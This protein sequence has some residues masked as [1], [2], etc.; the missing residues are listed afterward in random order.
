MLLK[1]AVEIIRLEESDNG[2]FG[3]LKINKQLFCWTLELQDKLNLKSNSSIPAQQY[4]CKK[5][6]SP[7][8]GKTF[9]I[10]NVPGRTHILFHPGNTT[11]D[12]EGCILLGRSIGYITDSNKGILSSKS[13]FREFMNIFSNTAI[14]HLTIKEEY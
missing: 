7:K 3:A 14:F 9:E 6:E 8:Y 5:I 13:V 12:T 1:P 2:T 4:F 11:K 10:C